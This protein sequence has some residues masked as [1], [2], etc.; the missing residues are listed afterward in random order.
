ME[1]PKI[2]SLWKRQGWYFDEKK[3]KDPTYQKNRQSFI[4]GDYACEEFG[5]IKEWDVYEKVDGTNIRVM[6]DGEKVKFGGRTN[7]AQIPCHLL[8]VL[9]ELFTVEKMKKIA[10]Q[11][12]DFSHG[13]KEH[14]KNDA[15]CYTKHS[16]HEREFPEA[17]VVQTAR[18]NT[19][20]SG[21]SP[22]SK[23]SGQDLCEQVS[24]DGVPGLGVERCL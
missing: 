12:P 11:S 18:D 8:E 2:N 20:A 16:H 6:F 10:T 13:V 24:A 7:A 5:L 21:S 15:L 17:N 14:D 19:R 23:L 22:C 9:Q 4:V 3:K 1:Y